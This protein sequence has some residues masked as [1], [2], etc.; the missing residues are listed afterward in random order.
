[1]Q[2]DR[3][4]KERLQHEVDAARAAWHE[5]RRRL[6][7]R[8]HEPGRPG[9]LFSLDPPA[10][11]AGEEFDGL[12]AAIEDDGPDRLRLVPATTSPLAGPADV[13]VAPS[14][15]TGA[16]VL[17][18]GFAL[19]IDREA[20]DPA[21][22]EGMLAPEDVLRAS[23]KLAELDAGEARGTRR[24]RETAREPLY[25]ELTAEL[26]AARGRLDASRSADGRQIAPG[27]AA[28]VVSFPA[29][30]RE[31]RPRRGRHPMSA[32][33]AAAAAVAL[34]ALGLGFLAGRASGPRGPGTADEAPLLGLPLAWLT[35]GSGQRGDVTTLRLGAEASHA[36]LILGLDEV[37]SHRLYR[38]VVRRQ[39][40]EELWRGELPAG[41]S[42]EVSAVLPR[43]ILVR[44]G[45]VSTLVV[46]LYGLRDGVAEPVGRYPLQVELAEP[47]NAN[48]R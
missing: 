11:D 3:H 7:N 28:G 22:R 30:R 5:S 16:L 9:D 26:D 4:R 21:T 19:R 47:L 14:S 46:E 37:P 48:R 18:C 23:A 1:M 45:T 43:R 13:V 42:V 31:R 8:R 44:D 24:Q 6:E 40:G 27:A 41:E 2:G 33:V 34:L 36:V 29:P 25:E 17:H 38:V 32:R 15:P 39:D 12:W 35:A 20:L 10:G